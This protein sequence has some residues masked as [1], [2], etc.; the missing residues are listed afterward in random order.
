MGRTTYIEKITKKVIQGCDTRDLIRIAN[1]RGCRKGGEKKARKVR[2][3]ETAETLLKP[4]LLTP[5][6]AVAFFRPYLHSESSKWGAKVYLPQEDGATSTTR[7]KMPPDSPDKW[8]AGPAL[9]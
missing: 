7:V 6:A 8:I 1:G 9:R 2:K 4:A 5:W 3:P